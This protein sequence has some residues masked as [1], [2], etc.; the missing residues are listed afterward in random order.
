MIRG[1]QQRA[2]PT[3]ARLLKKQEEKE[4]RLTVV[5]DAEQEMIRVQSAEIIRSQILA[6]LDK[7][8]SVFRT[9]SYNS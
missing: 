1:I 7:H 4:D 5:R 3:L 6:L 9:A 8:R 2:D